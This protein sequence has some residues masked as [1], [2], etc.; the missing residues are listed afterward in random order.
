[1]VRAGW[2]FF[3]GILLGVVGCGGGGQQ[4][5]QSA[6]SSSASETSLYDQGPRA[7]DAPVNEA[8]A[9]KGGDLFKT[10]T[11]STCHGFGVRITGPDLKDV[12]AQRT[13]RWMQQ[14]IQH[15]DIMTKQD[16][17]SRQ[18]LGTYAVQMPNLNI[19]DDDARALIEYIKKKHKEMSA[20]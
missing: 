12:A 13:A 11:C 5:E 18:L 2:L 8:L 4:A 1:M 7:A 3:L 9:A 16:P 15:P 14:Q 19:S 17:I 10:K 6:S 20:K